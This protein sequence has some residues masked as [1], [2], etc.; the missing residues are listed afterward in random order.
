MLVVKLLEEP[1]SELAVAP[2]DWDPAVCD[3]LPT[4]P[5]TPVEFPLELAKILPK[6][7]TAE[8]FFMQ[9]V[10]KISGNCEISPFPSRLFE[11]LSLIKILL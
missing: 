7:L 2:A 4:A 9:M 5:E 1:S 11:K 10:N 6:S 3:P 8:I